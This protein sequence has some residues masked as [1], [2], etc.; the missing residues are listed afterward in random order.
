MSTPGSDQSGPS[1]QAK[2]ARFEEQGG[3]KRPSPLILVAVTVVLAAVAGAALFALT[4]SAADAAVGAAEPEVGALPAAIEGY[5]TGSQGLAVKAATVGHDPYPLVEAQDGA[6]RLPLSTFDDEKAH[7][8]T[9]M[10]EGRP[11]EFFVLKSGDGV[12][13]AAFNACDV[14]FEAHRGYTQ[15][16]D[17]MV[18][19]NC[20]RRFPADQINVVQGGC[21][22]SP[23]ERSVSGETLIIQFEDLLTG[24]D[25][26]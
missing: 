20:G 18:C 16:G 10:H 17:T 8:Y 12:V 7:H 24:Q 2:R 1:R 23:L 19:N 5:R 11:L 25:L 14:C 21:N 15:E 4:R 6:V 3:R 22:P 26:F 13:R 9:F